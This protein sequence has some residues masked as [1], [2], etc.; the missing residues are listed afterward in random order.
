[1][2]DFES[3]FGEPRK[4]RNGIART[5]KV[6]ASGKDIGLRWHLVIND[7]LPRERRC[8]S[9]YYFKDDLDTRYTSVVDALR[10]AGVKPTRYWFHP[11]SDSYF[12][13]TGDEVD[14]DTALECV[15]MMQ[16]EWELSKSRH[17]PYC[18]GGPLCTGECLEHDE[19]DD[20]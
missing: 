10:A 1:M 20:L 6:L 11:E 12:T 15:E 5:D 9:W 19:S 2:Y 3:V 4:R 8:L 7:T 14:A 18:G 13:T 17:C 16:G